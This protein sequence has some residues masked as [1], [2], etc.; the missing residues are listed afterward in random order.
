[1]L[2]SLTLQ[3]QCDDLIISEYIEGSSN[4][5]AL[6]I[7]NPTDQTIDLSTYKVFLINNGG[8]ANNIDFNMVGTLAPYDVYVIAND[9]ADAAILAVADTAMPYNSVAHFNGD[10]AVGIIHNGDTIDA[11]GERYVDP[12]SYWDVDS[13][14]TKEFTLIRKKTIKEGQ[15]VW[16]VGAT[17]WEVH[18]QN[19]FS[20]IGTHTS[21][22]A[23]RA[24]SIAGV[25]TADADWN[26]TNKGENVEVTGIVYGIDLDGNAGISFTIIDTSA[27]I[28]IF[29]FVDVSDYVV[30]QGDE[31]TVRGE[32]DFYNG[33]TEVK[34][35][36]IKIV[37]Q[38]N[39][40]LKDPIEVDKPD[41]STESDYIK[42]TKVWIADTTTVW[43]SNG[44]VLLTNE[45]QDTFQIRID[46]DATEIAK[47]PVKY[48]TMNI[49]GIGGQFVVFAPYNSGYQIFAHF[50]SS[51]EEWVDKSSV[52]DVKLISNIYPN[53]S[54][55][56]IEIKT[57]E[58][59]NSVMVT[60][61]NGEVVFN[62][63]NF[64]VTNL[65][66]NLD[67]LSKGIYF[68][69]VGNEN[70]SAVKKVVLH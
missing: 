35:D 19:T 15:T 14:S 29:N 59:V 30:T 52:H 23:Y 1:M 64:R 24:S 31:I 61:L 42:I 11:I 40:V 32:I 63:S 36:S 67:Q 22:C 51:I 48:D 17:E 21:Y 46:K 39:N 5:K 16:A 60:S 28:N 55:G 13:G 45:K 6:E 44:N 7:Y 25:R 58:P 62:R 43:P 66:V 34:A 38:N 47:T 26:V 27:G 3:A 49:T 10:D 68:I 9:A 57:L 18:P 54:N 56:V 53:P 8:T 2:F 12:G 4:N 70:V 65:T 20:D 69:H 41:E 33:L 50:L 37:S